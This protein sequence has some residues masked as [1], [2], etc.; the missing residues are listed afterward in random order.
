MCLRW[1]EVGSWLFRHRG[2]VHLCCSHGRVWLGWRTVTA[3]FEEVTKETNSFVRNGK[4]AARSAN[5]GQTT[6]TRVPCVTPSTLVLFAKRLF[7]RLWLPGSGSEMQGWRLAPGMQADG[8]RW[9]YVWC[10]NLSTH[11][12]TCLDC[13]QEYA[14]AVHW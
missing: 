11:G 8:T 9:W 2:F 7:S 14:M 12:F 6:R 3:H 1:Q 5:N 4:R 10:C 13:F